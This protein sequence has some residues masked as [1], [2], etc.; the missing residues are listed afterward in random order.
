MLGVWSTV[1]D[2]LALTSIV[3]N[4]RLWS[5]EEGSLLGFVWRDESESTGESEFGLITIG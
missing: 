1:S 4:S 3:G 2:F 5:F